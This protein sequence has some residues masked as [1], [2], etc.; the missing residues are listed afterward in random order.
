MK[1]IKTAIVDLNCPIGHVNL[2]NFYVKNLKKN[3]SLLVLNKSIKKILKYNAA[4]YL[5]YNVNFL[6]K[7]YTFFN[8]YNLLINN[9]INQVIFLSYDPIYFLFFTKILIK[10][11]IKIYLIKHD[12]LNKKKYIKFICNKFIDKR[13]VRL[14]YNH[15]KKVFVVKNF[16]TRVYIIDHPLLKDTRFVKKIY[17][18]EYKKF[19]KT[20]V[21]NKYIKILVPTRYYIDQKSFYLFIKNFSEKTYFIAFSKRI[22]I[23]ID[24]LFVLKNLKSNMIKYMDYIYLPNNNKV[25]DTRISSWVYTAIAYN[26]KVILE[27]S[28]SSNY[29]KKRFP[30]F[31]IEAKKFKLKKP[32]KM[33]ILMHRRFIFKYNSNTIIRLK[34]IIFKT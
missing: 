3:T 29:E 34:K 16:K 20:I 18:N 1:K 28:I 30:N 7:I 22:K 25:Y 23:Q 10:K 19:K 2:I 6:K 32:K 8:L 27:K 21:N 13:T 26:K 17:S 33:H 11:K 24:N 12:T 15:E 9:K 4:L 14:V 5:N 31:I